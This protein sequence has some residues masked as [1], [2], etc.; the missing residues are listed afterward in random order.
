MKGDG[1]QP[2][3]CISEVCRMEGIVER[4]VILL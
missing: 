3:V 2:S 1:S 4:K